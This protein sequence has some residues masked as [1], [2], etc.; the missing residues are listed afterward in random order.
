MK[1]ILLIII[2]CTLFHCSSPTV[3]E[4]TQRPCVDAFHDKDLGIITKFIHKISR[5]T[6]QAASYLLTGIGYTTD[7]AIIFTGTI[8]IGIIVC[9]PLIIAEGS[10]KGTGKSSAA[11]I[12]AIT[13]G[14]ANG[15]N[16]K[17]GKNTIG[18]SIYNKTKKWRCPKV[19]HISRGLRRVASCH[20][21]NGDKSSA[22]Q[23][24]NAILSDSVL[25]R[26]V[27][28]KEKQKVNSQ[29]SKYSK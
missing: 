20:H 2:L 29:L 9:S 8:G 10:A 18:K 23:Q 17:V 27:G 5:G 21:K 16:W 13:R 12:E 28:K 11:C 25:S 26:C 14:I 24:L 19:D 6:T 7:F 1:H 4:H 22:K 3:K 15:I